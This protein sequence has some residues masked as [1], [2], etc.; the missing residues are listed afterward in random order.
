MA[1]KRGKVELTGDVEQIV[2]FRLGR[3]TFAIVVS[4][5]REIRKVEDITRVPKM[6]Q[7]IE[8]VMN[9]RGQITTVVDL[10]KRL[11]IAS[12]GAS[13]TAQ[14]RII[15]AEIGEN[16]LGIIVDAVEDVMRVPKAS[17]SPP[18]KTLAGTDSSALTGISKM[19]DKLIMMLDLEKVVG[20]VEMARLGGDPGINGT[21]EQKEFAEVSR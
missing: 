12:D 6:P 21:I 13:R 8:G 15:V 10:K 9:L 4:Q 20:G 5:V 11:N 3:E 17:I 19:P 16:Q 14:S 1:R 7:Y 18:P 2:S